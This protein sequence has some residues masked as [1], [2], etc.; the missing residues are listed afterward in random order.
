[1]VNALKTNQ[2]AENVIQIGRLAEPAEIIEAVYKIELWIH[3]NCF[4]LILQVK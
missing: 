4:H 1:M 3:E 2:V